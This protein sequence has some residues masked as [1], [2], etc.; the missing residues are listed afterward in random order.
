MTAQ[1][2]VVMEG[3]SMS[4]ATVKKQTAIWLN[5]EEQYL[6]LYNYNQLPAE[7]K[8]SI[9]SMSAKYF[10]DRVTYD[11]L[12]ECK[13]NLMTTALVDSED[14]TVLSSLTEEE[15]EITYR[16]WVVNSY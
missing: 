14:L 3:N 11:E 1:S 8:K 6:N 16:L 10:P 7:S 13:L 15:I 9:A 4:T 2:A 5:G 12:A